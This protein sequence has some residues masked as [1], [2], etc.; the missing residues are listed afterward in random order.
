MHQA[1]ASSSSA[2]IQLIGFKNT[3][4]NCEFALLKSGRQTLDRIGLLSL[5]STVVRHPSTQPCRQNKHARIR[6]H[7]TEHC[8]ATLQ[9]I[10]R[11]RIVWLYYILY[12]THMANHGVYRVFLGGTC[13]YIHT[14]LTHRHT[15]SHTRSNKPALASVIQP[16]RHTHSLF[17]SRSTLVRLQFDI[18]FADQRLYLCTFVHCRVARETVVIARLQK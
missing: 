18:Q 15:H 10:R 11:I 3:A 5:S 8:A 1:R 13:M 4:T 6:S 9:D 2:I 14:L 12:N 7:I 16:T 17:S